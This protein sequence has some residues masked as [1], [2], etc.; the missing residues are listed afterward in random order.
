MLSAAAPCLA[1]DHA[2]L[3]VV[4]VDAT[5][6]SKPL[7]VLEAVGS[8]LQLVLAGSG[9]GLVGSEAAASLAEVVAEV[10]EAIEEVEVSAEGMVEVAVE[11]AE[12][13]TEAIAVALGINPTATGLLMVHPPVLVV[14][15]TLVA[16]A[17]VVQ[18]TAAA[19]A[20]TEAIAATDATTAVGDPAARTMSLW[21]AET[22]IATA[23]VRVGMAAEMIL[24][25][26][27]VAMKAT[28]TIHDSAGDTKL[29]CCSVRS[30]MVCQKVTFFFA[31]VL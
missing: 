2:D 11:A 30:A 25:Q 17:T 26:G 21:V 24:A 16:E 27:S 31:I 1:G 4:L 10:L 9:L 14:L 23:I 22:G 15:A 20:G 12:E 8:V 19:V 18:A 28:T 5:T 7:L 3:A 13:A 6:P 29:S